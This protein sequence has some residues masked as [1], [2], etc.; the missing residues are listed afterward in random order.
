[1]H[2]LY[3]Q[4]LTILEEAVE[5]LS[6]CVPPPKLVTLFGAPIYRYLEKTSQQAIVQKLARL[7]TGL[8]AARLLLEHGFFQK[9]AA[10]H[11]ILDEIHE[12][13]CF[14]AYGL[15]F[16]KQTDVHARYLAAFYQEEF[17]AETALGST[18]RRKTPYR[19]EIQAFLAE[20]ES[21][22]G[23]PAMIAEI[24]RTLSKAYS[25]YVHAASP[26]IMEL[27]GGDP[28]HFRVRGML[29]S[30]FHR[31]HE[32]DIWNY[33]YRGILACCFSARALGA[34]EIFAEL[35]KFKHE[36]EQASGRT[37]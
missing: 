17:D 16:E 8:H 33:F 2:G 9:Q 6:K 26:H 22:V 28:P 13:I 3:A 12:D 5:H 15:L 10:L 19:K 20:I 27:Y 25:G 7:V 37:S 24:G 31:D 32:F 14:L 21:Q 1:M 18:Q 23:D 4:A 29:G 11:R 36:F 35:V 30:E 34:D